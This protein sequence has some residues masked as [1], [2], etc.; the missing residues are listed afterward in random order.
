MGKHFLGI[1]LEDDCNCKG[2]LL[3]DERETTSKYKWGCLLHRQ[4]KRY[5]AS[6]HSETD[7]DRTFNYWWSDTYRSDSCPL[8]KSIPFD[9]MLE[10]ILAY[11][12]ATEKFAEESGRVMLALQER[13]VCGHG[14]CS[15]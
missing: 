14:N 11:R 1:E 12:K 4:D 13:L 9:R 6:L 8:D 5:A 15:E 7:E 10:D 3:L 2:C